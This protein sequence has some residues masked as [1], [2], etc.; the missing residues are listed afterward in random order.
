MLHRESHTPMRAAKG[1][2]GS[3]VL[4]LA[5]KTDMSSHPCNHGERKEKNTVRRSSEWK[6]T[7]RSCG[8]TC[9]AAM[10]FPSSLRPFDSPHLKLAVPLC[11]ESITKAVSKSRA[12]QMGS[13]SVGAM[14]VPRLVL[15]F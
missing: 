15:D 1:I 14:A 2:T 10:L 9:S 7:N 6:E 8:G 4:S 5:S 13:M 12:A 3:G 11:E